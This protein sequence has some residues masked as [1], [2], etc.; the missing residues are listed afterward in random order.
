MTKR[1]PYLSGGILLLLVL[2]LALLPGGTGHTA[3]AEVAPRFRDYY[4]QHDGMRVLGI[5][6]LPLEQ[7]NGYPAQLFEKG[8]IEEHRQD[9]TNPTGPLC[10]GGSPTN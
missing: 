4:D 1:I 9:T 5:A 6:H 7:V 2:T 3:A 10:T 8:R